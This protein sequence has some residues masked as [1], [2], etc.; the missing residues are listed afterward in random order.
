MARKRRDPSPA[1][2]INVG[3]LIEPDNNGFRATV[4]DQRTNPDPRVT[5]PHILLAWAYAE[6]FSV[7]ANFRGKTSSRYFRP[8]D[9]ITRWLDPSSSPCTSNPALADQATDGG[10]GSTTASLPE[11]TGLMSA[12]AYAA[13][14]ATTCARIFGQIKDMIPTGQQV[15]DSC[16][17]ARAN[18]AESG[19]PEAVLARIVQLQ[20]LVA[21]EIQRLH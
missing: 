18:L 15:A 6:D 11:I 7:N 9:P 14:C 4:T 16:D 3:D 2:D 10:A 1:G 20:G 17:Q 12:S 13:G 19:L 5:E 21:R 8:A